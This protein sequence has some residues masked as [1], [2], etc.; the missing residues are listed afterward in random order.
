MAT[1]QRLGGATGGFPSGY[2]NDD[3]TGMNQ[4]WDYQALTTAAGSPASFALLTTCGITNIAINLTGALSLTIGVGTSTTGP[5]VGD[6]LRLSFT[7]D[8]TNRTVT[9][10]TGFAV[11]ASTIVVTGS[12]F[13]TVDFMF[14]GASWQETARSI[15]V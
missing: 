9:F 15:T 8:S 3:N 4:T 5:Y 13:A 6:T 12:K 2:N 7:P 11:T 1:I 10:S 14:N